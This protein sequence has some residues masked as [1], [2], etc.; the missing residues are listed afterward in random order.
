M[1]SVLTSSKDRLGSRSRGDRRLPGRRGRVEDRDREGER[2]HLHQVAVLELARFGRQRLAVD[3]CAIATTQV[4]DVDEL[5]DD[6][7]LGMLS[8]DLF[9]IGPKVTG[10]ASADLETRTNQRDHF[11]L[12]FASNNYE[13]HFHGN[14][15][16][17]YGLQR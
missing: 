12:G 8:T 3:E 11:T 13:L 1:S 7:E 5:A 16:D 2:A 15:P 9:T 14:R 6:R 10:F 4:S 17:L